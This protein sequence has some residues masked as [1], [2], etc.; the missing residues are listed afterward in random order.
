MTQSLGTTL[1]WLSVGREVPVFPGDMSLLGRT[2][3]VSIESHKYVIR[4]L[5]E[6][7]RLA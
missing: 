4:R 7:G 3:G 1:R 2:I 5:G 6:L